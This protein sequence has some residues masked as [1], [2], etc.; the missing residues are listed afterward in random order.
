MNWILCPQQTP[1][2][3]SQTYTWSHIL[4]CAV[5]WKHL[6]PLRMNSPSASLPG[7]WGKE[8][9]G[10][11]EGPFMVQ[12]SRQWDR[13]GLSAGRQVSCLQEL[14]APCQ[15]QKS[16]GFLNTM[17]GAALPV[18]MVAFKG[19]CTRVLSVMPR[20]LVAPCKTPLAPFPRA[21]VRLLTCREEERT[22]SV[23]AA[24]LLS[25]QLESPV[26]SHPALT[27][28]SRLAHHTVHGQCG[29]QMT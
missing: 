24:A 5:G 10:Q 19:L 2:G 15:S 20:E 9:R 18:T 27:H 7:H 3:F 1:E 6:R 28:S 16:T 11:A 4:L 8:D 12:G 29:M 23:A 21:L 26:S 13:R 25:T 17:L 22:V 14:A